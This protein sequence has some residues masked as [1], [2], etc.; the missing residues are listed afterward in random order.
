MKE[1]L[2]CCHQAVTKAKQF[3]DRKLHLP[4]RKGSPEKGQ[5]GDLFLD[6]FI[7]MSTLPVSVHLMH[8]WCL[9]KW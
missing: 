2:R 8:A 9:R 6:L 1:G 4:A 3:Y 7:H 5:P